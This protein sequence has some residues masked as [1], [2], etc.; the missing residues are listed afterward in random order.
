MGTFFEIRGVKS[1]LPKISIYWWMWPKRRCKHALSEKVSA[2]NA[3][4]TGSKNDPVIVLRS[5]LFMIVQLLSPKTHSD[6]AECLVHSQIVPVL[7]MRERERKREN[8][9][10]R[11]AFCKRHSHITE[12]AF[13]YKFNYMPSKSS[14]HQTKH[15]R[16][17]L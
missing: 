3:H 15:C 13:L 6:R 8:P 11:V 16:I 12:T 4:L 9:H 14:A 2:V 10:S 17:S 5:V 7:Y 1:T